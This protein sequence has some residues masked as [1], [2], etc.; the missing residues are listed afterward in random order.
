MVGFIFIDQQM[1]I[2]LPEPAKQRAALQ[3]FDQMG[4][5]VHETRLEKGESEKTIATN[6]LAAGVYLIQID[7][8][9]GALRKKSDGDTS[10]LIFIAELN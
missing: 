8:P 10:A 3:L 9:K 4:K 5:L 7:S 1:T 6:A 2:I